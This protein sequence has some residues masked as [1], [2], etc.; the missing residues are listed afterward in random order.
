M[1]VVDRTFYGCPTRSIFVSNVTPQTPPA[2]ASARHVLAPARRMLRPGPL[3]GR[4]P[5]VAAMVVLFLVPYLVLSAAL[6]PIEPLIAGTLHMSAQTTSLAAGLANA[7]YAAG[8]VL[9]VQFAQ[10]LHQRRMMLIYATALV[11]GSVL[12][13]SA[14][15]A[16]M[17]I[18]G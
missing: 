11:I 4:Y 3:A 6:Q 2:L 10:H 1:F 17:F 12:A 9:A 8:T 14:V 15:N 18:V 5:A 13:A 16:P 7:A